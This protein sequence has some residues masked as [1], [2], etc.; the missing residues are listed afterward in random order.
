MSGKGDAAPLGAQR[1]P[2]EYRGRPVAKIPTCWAEPTLPNPLT[3]ADVKKE[4]DDTVT[5]PGTLH[6]KQE[7][8]HTR[9]CT[10][11]RVQKVCATMII[12]GLGGNVP[13]L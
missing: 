10:H 9:V 1:K 2:K 3:G 8:M 6:R 13:K 11:R 4:Q 7:D 5:P 12:A